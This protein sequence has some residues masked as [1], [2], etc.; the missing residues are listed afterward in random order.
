MPP[1]QAAAISAALALVPSRVQRLARVV[2][3][4]RRRLRAN[5]WKVVDSPAPIIVLPVGAEDAA[6]ECAAQAAER[7]VIVS[8]IRYPS[9][10]LGQALLRLTAH[11][12][13]SE[14]DIA[15]IV[16]AIGPVPQ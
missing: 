4:L 2:H 7:G 13:Y 16:D 10:P 5:G 1:S 12:D 14:D 9:V 3:N 8:P 15:L 11:A 6:M